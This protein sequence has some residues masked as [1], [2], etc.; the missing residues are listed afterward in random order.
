M[1]PTVGGHAS[2]AWRGVAA[3]APARL[4]KKKK[5]KGKTHRFVNSGRSLPQSAVEG[6]RTASA[7]AQQASAAP[8]AALLWVSTHDDCRVWKGG[9]VGAVGPAALAPRPPL[10]VDARHR[11]GGTARSLRW[12]PAP[13]KGGLLVGC[14]AR[15]CRHAP[16]TRAP[17]PPR[18]RRL[19]ARLVRGGSPTP[20]TRHGPRRRPARDASFGVLTLLGSAPCSPT[21][22]PWIRSWWALCKSLRNGS[23]V[24]SLSRC[25]ARRTTHLRLL[26]RFINRTCS[27]RHP[28]RPSFPIGRRDTP[29]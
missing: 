20:S 12:T 7:H 26:L 6:K 5:K 25:P 27:R 2:L 21:L 4:K 15:C 29:P 11:R 10:A 28:T 17:I 19:R 14:L 8:A 1:S 22:E 24:R 3:V 18:A 16:R 13:P 23:P 9:V